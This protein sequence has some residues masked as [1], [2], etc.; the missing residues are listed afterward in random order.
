MSSLLV[1]LSLAG[2]AAAQLVN[3]NGY[4]MVPINS[5][6]MNAASSS[7]GGYY[8]SSAPAQATN[9]ATSSAAASDA[10]Y[11]SPPSSTYDIYSMMP[12]E[13]MTAGGYSS[14]ACGYGY[15]KSSDG[16]CQSQSWYSFSGC[17]ETI[18]INECVIFVFA[19]VLFT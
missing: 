4:S 10:Q 11:T 14:L 8:G 9:Y 7:S 1:G 13:S 3:V 5:Q 2:A 6:A 15:S 18:I 19:R 17:Y 12:Y 16:S